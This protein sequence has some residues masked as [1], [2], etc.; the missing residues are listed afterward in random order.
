M[1]I[2]DILYIFTLNGIIIIIF[3]GRGL[4]LSSNLTKQLEQ[5]KN[6]SQKATLPWMR[7]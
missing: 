6:G 7:I 2:N 5:K 4:I 3:T 1:Y